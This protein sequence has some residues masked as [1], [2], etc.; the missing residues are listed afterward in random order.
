VGV[1]SQRAQLV[2]SRLP[3]HAINCAQFMYAFPAFGPASFHLMPVGF[4]GH[5]PATAGA[6]EERRH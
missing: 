2:L 4:E 1:K 3:D 5:L 6:K